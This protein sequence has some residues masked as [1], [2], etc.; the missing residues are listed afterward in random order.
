LLKR[1]QLTNVQ[2]TKLQG[3]FLN[4]YGFES[5][6]HLAIRAKSTLPWIRNKRYCKPKEYFMKTS[7]LGTASACLLV[8]AMNISLADQPT[9][10]TDGG[11]KLKPSADATL[12][13]QKF[14]PLVVNTGTLTAGFEEIACGNKHC[15]LTGY[16]G[17][18]AG[19]G[20]YSSTGLT[21]GKT[22]DAIYDQSGPESGDGAWLVVE[23]FTANPG[24]TWLTSI[25]CNGVALSEST[26]TYAYS[27]STG[28]A[29]WD[30]STSF[31]FVSG[32]KYSCSINHS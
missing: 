16:Q 4:G 2:Q 17:G 1:L 30:W 28:Q 15:S 12:I 21:G 3:G 26:A 9:V 18:A 27:S 23:G 6:L 25:T 11:V 13:V 5:F 20:S 32:T 31:N 22:I 10:V 8:G 19:F 14:G 24:K 7:F 29:S